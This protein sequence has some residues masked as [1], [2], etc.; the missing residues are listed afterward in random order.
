MCLSCPRPYNVRRI[1][2]TP[3]RHR[4]YLVKGSTVVSIMGGLWGAGGTPRLRSGTTDASCV[5]RGSPC[6]SRGPEPGPARVHRHRAAPGPTPLPAPS[7]GGVANPRGRPPRSCPRASTGQAAEAG[8]VGPA[9]GQH[10]CRRDCIVSNSDPGPSLLWC[11]A[12]P[13]LDMPGKMRNS[14]GGPSCEC[15]RYLACPCASS[16]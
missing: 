15:S 8:R 14:R 2:S 6:G 16:V 4:R 1:L 12:H 13:R 3:F 9:L 7:P 11:W 5:A 10:R